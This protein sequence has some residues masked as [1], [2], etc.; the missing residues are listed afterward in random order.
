MAGGFAAKSVER[1]SGPIAA[2]VFLVLAGCHQ[3][4][5]A[6]QNACAAPS[7]WLTPGAKTGHPAEEFAACLRDQAYEARS[8]SVPMQSIVAG[9]IAQ[10]HVR[11]DQFEGSIG[12]PT[13]TLPEDQRQAAERDA[14]AQASAAI[15]QYRQ[16]AGR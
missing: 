3:G 16:C 14:E 8:L 10:C 6:D 2:A 13:D 5:A 15:T 9:V 7:P 12:D 1:A 11:V 4:A